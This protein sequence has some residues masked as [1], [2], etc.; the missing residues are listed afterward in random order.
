M[1]TAAPLSPEQV[2]DL[3]AMPTA[4]QAFAALNIG[5]TNGYALIKSGEFP[6]EVVK[7][8]RAFRVRKADLLA[9]LGLTQTAAAEVQSAAATN[10]DAPEVQS[11]AP[12]E[13]PAHTSK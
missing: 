9:F 3:P 5:E 11:G 12:V 4:L 7:F 10:D 6:I 8:G 2:R 1:T 13:Q